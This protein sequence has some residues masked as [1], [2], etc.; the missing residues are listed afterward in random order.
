[1]AHTLYEDLSPHDLIW[2]AAEKSMRGAIVSNSDG[3]IYL[4]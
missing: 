4:R 2:E 3:M 1:M